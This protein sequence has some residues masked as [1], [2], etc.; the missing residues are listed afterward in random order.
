MSDSAGGVGGSS[1]G[2]GIGGDSGMGGGSDSSTS[3]SIGGLNSG[4]SGIGNSLEDSKTSCHSS[5]G[6]NLA[7]SPTTADTLSQSATTADLLSSAPTTAEQLS[8]APTPA[9]QLAGQAPAPNDNSGLTDQAEAGLQGLSALAAR[10]GIGAERAR[11]GYNAAVSQ[12]DPKD[13]QGRTAAKATAR[14]ATPP[15]TRTVIEATRPGLGPKPGSVASANKTNIG[16]NQ[17]AG[18]LGNIGRG[19]AVA[20]VALGAARIATADNKTEEAA[21]VAGGALGGIAA[22]SLVGAKLGALGANPITIGAGAVI[23][24]IVGGIAGEKAVDAAIGWA[25]SWF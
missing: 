8:T 4:I 22:G 25:K 20:G 16:A 12:M 23:G 9:T 5:T 15:A 24:G 18:R 3:E 21:R 10:E 14:A 2:S 6:S 13:V 19:F 1:G 17:L 7:N 11:N